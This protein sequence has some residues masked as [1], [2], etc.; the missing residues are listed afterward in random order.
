[1]YVSNKITNY[2]GKLSA[3]FVML[4]A[5][6][7]YCTSAL[8]YSM[9]KWVLSDNI[10]NYLPYMFSYYDPEL[11]HSNDYIND[12]IRN[13]SFSAAYTAL[14]QTAYMVIDPILL[15][16]LLPYILLITVA[17][18]FAMIGKHIAGISGSISAFILI[19][20]SNIF[21]SQMVGALP[22]C[23][24]YPIAALGIYAITT[25][26]PNYL[27]LST[28]LAA[29]IYPVISLFS[30]LSL[31]VFAL[32]PHNYGGFA[33]KFTKKNI[34]LI[35]LTIL[36]YFIII[37]FT[38]LR[39]STYNADLSYSITTSGYDN[40]AS[41][42]SNILGSL[43]YPFIIAILAISFIFC[44]SNNISARRLSLAII[45]LTVTCLSLNLFS[46]KLIA[47]QIQ[48]FYL[49][50]I[51]TLS[52]AF[53]IRAI[54][55]IYNQLALDYSRLNLLKTAKL[56]TSSLLIIILFIAK[57]TNVD[58]LT[59]IG[60]NIIIPTSQRPIYEFIQTLP[61]NSVIAGWPDSKDGIV[62]N[63]S[64]LSKRQ[65]FFSQGT[66]ER[67]HEEQKNIIRERMNAII[68]AFFSLDMS[69]II[70]L[71]DNWKVNYLVVDTNLLIGSVPKYNGTMSE[72]NWL[73]ARNWNNHILYQKN[74][75]IYN[76]INK[77]TIFRQ[78]NIYIL[79]LAKL[80]SLKN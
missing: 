19:L 32:V 27:I 18:L 21:I 36:S 58:K 34:A 13:T 4:C 54:S 60:F 56:I 55:Y 47:N 20:S 22:H 73:I 70:S 25:K 61:K 1:M 78:N 74:F 68:N 66:Y 49:P 71:R 28:L 69:D 50:L 43:S 51:I 62:D 79:D 72:F 7:I 30:L 16:K 44:N 64:Y 57:P 15:S 31:I 41:Y 29:L 42:I 45:I 40:I 3:A 26:R 6:Y 11:L 17:T 14:Y 37:D 9:D 38:Y 24:A 77:S 10:R 52:F 12:L 23:F 48:L 53:L 5:V 59:N 39:I 80:G 33:L 75:A 8:Y 76:A 67:L 35:T 65:A 2:L 46:Y 63:I